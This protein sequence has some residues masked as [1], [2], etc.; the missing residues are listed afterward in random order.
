MDEQVSDISDRIRH[1]SSLENAIRSNFQ[2]DHLYMELKIEDRTEI[3]ITFGENEEHWNKNKVCHD[4]FGISLCESHSLI[5]RDF[6]YYCFF[7]FE[8]LLLL[9]LNTSFLTK[10]K[11]AP[12]ISLFYEKSLNKSVISGPHTK[13]A[14]ITFRI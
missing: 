1:Q 14:L 4:K 10:K 3:F 9:L 11:T 5:F 8:T 12:L 7:F 2:F 6:F 13:P